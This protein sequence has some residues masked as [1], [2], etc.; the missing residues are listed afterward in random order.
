MIEKPLAKDAPSNLAII[1]RYILQPNV[2]GILKEIKPDMRG[3]VQI[4]DALNILA[5]KGEV[6]ALKF[7][8]K[9]I[10][11][12]SMEGYIEANNFLASI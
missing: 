9:R 3:E 1:G 12:G 8:G 6:L 11:C 10:D 2:F 4:T 5:M 7:K